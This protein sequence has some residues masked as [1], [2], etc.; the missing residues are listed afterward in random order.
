MKTHKVVGGLSEKIREIV[1]E[2]DVDI[3]LI[4][5]Q[6]GISR[7][8]FYSYMYYD[9]TPNAVNLMKIAKQFNVSADWL[10]G[11]SDIKQR[12]TNIDNWIEEEQMQRSKGIDRKAAGESIRKLR[13]EKGMSRAEFGFFLGVEERTIGNWENGKN[14]PTEF[15]AG[16]LKS[17]GWKLPERKADAS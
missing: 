1:L 6:M 7:S 14:L 10:L 5:K 8:L 16:L 3:T 12:K 2:K 13:E 4:A 15:N 11:L 9:I 17:I